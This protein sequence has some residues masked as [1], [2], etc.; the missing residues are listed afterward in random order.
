M[1]IKYYF[2]ENK[3][4]SDMKKLSI[5][6]INGNNKKYNLL[7]WFLNSDF[8]IAKEW[9][10]NNIKIVLNEK[11]LELIE[12]GEIVELIIKK[13]I[14]TLNF[15]QHETFNLEIKDLFENIDQLEMT[16]TINTNE[17]YNIMLEWNEILNNN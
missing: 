2:N 3:L 14:T 6:I 11:K 15:I 8:L 17:L 16:S 13:N 1:N 12:R 4:N 7:E 9:W 10:I 5:K